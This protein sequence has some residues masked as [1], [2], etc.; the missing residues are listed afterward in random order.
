ME[1]HIKLS[2]EQKLQAQHVDAL[3]AQIREGE[4]RL[5]AYIKAQNKPALVIRRAIK[6]WL[7]RLFN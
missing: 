1:I 5:A 2:P 7:V 4:A 3:R 6:G